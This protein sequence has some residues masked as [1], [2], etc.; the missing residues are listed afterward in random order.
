[1]YKIF[2]KVMQLKLQPPLM[3]VINLEQTI[4][5]PLQFM[6]DNIILVQETLH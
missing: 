3:E 2:A 4:F 6:L 1:M 5:L